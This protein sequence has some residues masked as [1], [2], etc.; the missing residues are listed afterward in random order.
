GDMIKS[1]ITISIG[2]TAAEK[3]LEVSLRYST[4][5]LPFFIFWMRVKP[6]RFRLFTMISSMYSLSSTTM[7][8]IRSRP[9]F[10]LSLFVCTNDT[11]DPVPLRAGYAFAQTDELAAYLRARIQSVEYNSGFR[12]AAR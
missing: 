12:P 2:S 6:M 11:F 5:S 1:E 9:R 7:M 4:A 3:P 10:S 8:E